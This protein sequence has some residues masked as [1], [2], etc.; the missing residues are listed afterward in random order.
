[1]SKPHHAPSTAEDP[2]G[3][4]RRAAMKAALGGAATAAVLAAPRVEGFRLVP[5]YAAAATAT[6]G[7]GLQKD[8]NGTLAN[9]C[10][11]ASTIGCTYA[12]GPPN[13]CSNAG[14]GSVS[15]T[16]TD[17]TNTI[18]VTITLD[19]GPDITGRDIYILQ[20]NGTSCLA[21][22]YVGDWL[23][24]PANGPQTFTATIVSGARLFAV[25][26]PVSGGG[27]TDIYTSFQVN[28]P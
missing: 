1:V 21:T 16:R 2:R 7:G 8:P 27:G 26:M 28:L 12:G 19:S 11:T 3:I 5:D 18:S 22:T 14:R 17:S 6:A 9:R 15:F 10:T 20:S 13:G 24:S 23:A 25:H 4:D